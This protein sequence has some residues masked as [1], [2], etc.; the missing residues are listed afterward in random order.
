M[1]TPTK[2][3]RGD[4]IAIVAP[5][6]KIPAEK[7]ENAVQVLQDWGLEVVLG[8]NMFKT[9]HQYSAIDEDRVSDFQQML[10]DNSVKTI[11]CTRGGYGSVRIIDRLDFAGFIKNPKWII[12]FSDITVFHS[13]IHANYGIE[14]LHAPMTAGL[15]DAF[16]AKSLKKCLFGEPISYDITKLHLSREGEAEGILVGGNLAIIC[17]LVGTKS[18]IHTS[19][20]ILFIEDVGEYLYRLDRMMW[21]MKRSGKLQ[22]LAGLIVGGMSDMED[23]DT[24]FGKTAYEIVADAVAEYDYPVCYGFPA[25]HQENNMVLILGRKVKLAVTNNVNFTFE[26]RTSNLEH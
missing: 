18:D 22:N 23:N 15:T 9:H 4:K 16:S 8:K 25:G 19:G 11:I 24:P 5:A 20:K 21:Q 6:G 3:F 26:H 17:S 1:I 14:T 10:N 12:G 7:V 2:L 13:H